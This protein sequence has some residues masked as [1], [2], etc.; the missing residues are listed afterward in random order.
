MIIDGEFKEFANSEDMLV[1]SKEIL[2]NTPITFEKA[3]TLANVE[4]GDSISVA[5]GKLSKL[6]EVLEQDKADVQQQINS[7]EIFRGYKLLNA[8]GWYKIF[9]F[10]QSNSENI[11]GIYG[12]AILLQLSQDFSAAGSEAVQMAITIGSPNKVDFNILS[13]VK[14]TDVLKNVRV[15]YDTVDK[16]NYLEIY[17][18]AETANGVSYKI[19]FNSTKTIDESICGVDFEVYNPDREVVISSI[20]LT[21]GNARTTDVRNGIREVVTGD[22]SLSDYIDAD[23]I[24]SWGHHSGYISDLPPD[25]HPVGIF[26]NLYSIGDGDRQYIRQTYTP[27]DQDVF[28]TRQMNMDLGPNIRPWAVFYPTGKCFM[29]DNFSGEFNEI[30]LM[31]QVHERMKVLA[32]SVRKAGETVQVAW[33]G[34]WTD[35]SWFSG[36]MT[37]FD[38]YYYTLFYKHDQAYLAYG[39]I[40]DNGSLISFK[41][42]STPQYAPYLKVWRNGEWTSAG[43]NLPDN[44]FYCAVVRVWGV[45]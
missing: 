34:T 3:T 21:E 39:S 15:V 1:V 6:Y 25:I 43:G 7:K 37:T 36:Q 30:N 26:D 41:N 14:N 32:N 8:E 12:D 5:L 2:E 27:Y 11:Q 10:G 24:G 22:I 28:L 42:V 29:V 13:I 31:E 33:L 40:L 38:K 18:G 17:Y 4:S 9:G 19:Y 23:H 20:R 16:C 44:V 35:I 45:R